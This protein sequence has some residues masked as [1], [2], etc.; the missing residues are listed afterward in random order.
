MSQP[1]DWRQLPMVWWWRCNV[2]PLLFRASLSTPSTT[3]PPSTTHAGARLTRSLLR[4]LRPH[5]SAPHLRSSRMLF[6]STLITSYSLADFAV[7]LAL[8]HLPGFSFLS[9]HGP[10]PP[11]PLVATSSSPKDRSLPT[12]ASR[13]CSLDCIGSSIPRVMPT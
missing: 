4:D 8:F 6:E 2:Q 9:D 1:Q 7:F 13:L 5:V 10:F 12:C 3:S 11:P